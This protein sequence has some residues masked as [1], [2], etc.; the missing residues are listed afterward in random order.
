VQSFSQ[1]QAQ[2]QT[3]LNRW[4]L[5]WSETYN[6]WRIDG[7]KETTAEQQIK[8]VDL[9]KTFASKWFCD[10]VI[11]AEGDMYIDDSDALTLLSVL[12]RN[13]SEK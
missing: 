10:K 9:Q 11:I 5:I 12:S 2:T 4:F 1:F 13:V 3:E 7:T 6:D 8:I